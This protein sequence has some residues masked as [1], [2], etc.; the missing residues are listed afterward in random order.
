VFSTFLALRNGIL[1]V[2]PEGGNSRAFGQVLAG[3]VVYGTAG[4]LRRGV[5]GFGIG[6]KH[7]VSA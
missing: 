6:W 5:S 3:F 4:Q 1:R 7:S 2:V